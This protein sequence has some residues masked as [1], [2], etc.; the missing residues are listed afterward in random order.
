MNPFTGIAAD[1]EARGATVHWGECG[2]FIAA[3]A[4]AFGR[5]LY[6]V[7]RRD[8]FAGLPG[9]IPGKAAALAA[10]AH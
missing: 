8:D 9:L 5:T 7:H 6:R 2:G 3:V 1:Y 4:K 10:L